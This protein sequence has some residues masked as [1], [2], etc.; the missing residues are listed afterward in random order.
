MPAQR[1][2]QGHM[3]RDV[4][5]RIVKRS[6]R[7]EVAVVVPRR[8]KPSRVFSLEKYLKMREEPRKHKP[9]THRK[10]KTSPPDP[11]GA[12]DGRVLE[13]LSRDKIYQ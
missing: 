12:V 5:Q 4:A 3:P 6:A 2:N 1:R 8:G 13:R 7:D 9:W 11:L 10:G